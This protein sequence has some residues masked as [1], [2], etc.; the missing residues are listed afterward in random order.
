MAN[1]RLGVGFRFTTGVEFNEVDQVFELFK[2]PREF[3]NS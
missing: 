1:R 3:V 2:K